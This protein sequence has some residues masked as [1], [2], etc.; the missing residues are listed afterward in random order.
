[1]NACIAVSH[2]QRDISCKSMHPTYAVRTHMRVLT[3]LIRC[4]HM[5]VACVRAGVE[6]AYWAV[7]AA[8]VAACGFVY[9]CV[10]VR[11]RVSPKCV[12]VRDVHT[13][14]CVHVCLNSPEYHLISGKC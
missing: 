5:C 3:K 14:I 2:W 9:V 10:L 1:M 4:V 11:A 6:R 7:F 13:C 8:R 12:Y